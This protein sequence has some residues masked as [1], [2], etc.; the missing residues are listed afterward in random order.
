MLQVFLNINVFGMDVQSAIEVPRFVGYS[1][2]YS[3]RTHLYCPGRIYFEGRI[4]QSTGEEL[5]QLGHKVYWWDDWSWLGGGACAIF[6][7][8]KNGVMHGGADPRRSA[9]ALG[10]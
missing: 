6:V 7:D 2:P 5:Q 3:S 10:R 9:Y 1:Y 4:P 8:H